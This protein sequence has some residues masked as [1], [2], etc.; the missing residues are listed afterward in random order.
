[1]ELTLKDSAVRKAI[2]DYLDDYLFEFYRS[3]VIKAAGIPARKVLIEQV[4][5]D[6]KFQKNFIKYLSNYIDGDLMADAVVES[7]PNLDAFQ[8]VEA[9]FN[10]Q[11]TVD[12]ENAEMVED[13]VAIKKLTARGYKVTK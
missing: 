11:N 7:C 2:G 5:A 13:Q 9:E 10:Q 3:D 8:R 12:R 4:M 1:M 6:P